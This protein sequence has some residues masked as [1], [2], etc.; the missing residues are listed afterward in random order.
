LPKKL[1]QLPSEVHAFALRAHVVNGSLRTAV[2]AAVAAALPALASLQH[3]HIDRH[4]D[5]TPAAAFGET[6]AQLTALRSLR[7]DYVKPP[8]ATALVRTVAPVTTLT[9]LHLV[10]PKSLPPERSMYEILHGDYDEP[11]DADPSELADALAPLTRLRALTLQRLPMSESGYSTV[12]DTFTQLT[13]CDFTN[14]HFDFEGRTWNASNSYM[15]E[16]IDISDIE[17][18]ELA[19]FGC[20]NGDASP[21][22]TLVLRG[23]CLPGR[24]VHDL[25]RAG[26]WGALLPLSVRLV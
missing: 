9:N 10:A 2:S 19:A 17:H 3:L 25:H 6:L 22:A 7:I 15:A 1:E 12:R 18:H 13:H 8:V 14:C 5:A 24:A 21:L 4:E 23:N 20:N 26:A 11:P 16:F